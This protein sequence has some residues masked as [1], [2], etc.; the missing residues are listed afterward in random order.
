MVF[1]GADLHVKVRFVKFFDCKILKWLPPSFFIASVG[2]NT[3]A[4][5]AFLNITAAAAPVFCVLHL[6][7]FFPSLLLRRPSEDAA[8]GQSS[9]MLLLSP[10]PPEY[11]PLSVHTQYLCVVRVVVVAGFALNQTRLNHPA[12]QP[13]SNPL[14]DGLTGRSGGNENEQRQLVDQTYAMCGTQKDTCPTQGLPIFVMPHVGP[15]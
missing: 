14:S 3:S 9:L 2:T 11:P 1:C 15:V 12:N 5:T 8:Q 6:A 13:A 4:T 7:S 10:P